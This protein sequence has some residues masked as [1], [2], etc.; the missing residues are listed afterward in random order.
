MLKI[1]TRTGDRGQTSLFGGKRVSKD[2]LQIEAV[3]S[4]D[5]LNSAIGVAIAQIQNSKLKIKSYS[6]KVKSELEKVQHDLFSIGAS[7]ASPKQRTKN[8][9][10]KTESLE[11]RTAGF[12]TLIDEL[13]K[14]LPTL[15][16]FILPGGGKA[17]SALH[18]ARTICRRA[19]RRIIALDKKETVDPDILKY[20]NRLSDLLFTMARFINM[21]EKKK[22][23]IWT[24]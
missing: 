5:E 9:E 2:S 12:E 8:R 18:F 23:T 7:L 17:G 3:G 11:Q 16:N 10:L 1:Y 24:Q 6:A 20:F 13:A 4:V 14:D 22:E 19:E 15:R 21:K